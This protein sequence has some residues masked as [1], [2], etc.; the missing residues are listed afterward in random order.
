MDA[1]LEGTRIV[2]S[3]E[4][5]IVK[6]YLECGSWKL[7]D[8]H[9]QAGKRAIAKVLDHH[10]RHCLHETEQKEQTTTKEI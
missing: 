9:P 6:K 7:A 5:E 8:I 1:Q 4:H 3:P 2:L 10:F